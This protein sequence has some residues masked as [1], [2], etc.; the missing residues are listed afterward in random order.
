MLSAKTLRP[1]PLAKVLTT[2]TAAIADLVAND[3][4]TNVPLVAN[5]T[6]GN[7]NLE[8]VCLISK[9]KDR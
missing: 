2:N 1:L 7:L 5:G 4:R 8:E 6:F 3:E 9:G